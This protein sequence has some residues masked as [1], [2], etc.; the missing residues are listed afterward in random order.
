MRPKNNLATIATK[1]A[2]DAQA[3]VALFVGLS[4]GSIGGSK[5]ASTVRLSDVASVPLPG[6]SVGTSH[7]NAVAS[8]RT[9]VASFRLLFV[10]AL[11]YGLFRTLI[12]WAP[13]I[14]NCCLPPMFAAI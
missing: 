12:R 14:F 8:T 4:V 2:L 3:H 11:V 6:N 7:C 10:S 5:N 1:V 13:F 9:P